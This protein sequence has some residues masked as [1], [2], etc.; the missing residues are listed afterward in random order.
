MLSDEA[1]MVWSLAVKNWRKK[2]MAAK[3]LHI[4][5]IYTWVNTFTPVCPID[6]NMVIHR[7]NT[8]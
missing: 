2:R 7:E 8:I 5:A 1:K 4:Y 3:R 6:Q